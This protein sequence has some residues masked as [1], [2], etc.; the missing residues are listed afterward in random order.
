M[1]FQRRFINNQ[2]V[3]KRMLSIISHQENVNH[4]HSEIPLHTYQDD[5]NNNSNNKNQ[6]ITSTGGDVKKL[7]SLCTVGKNV[8]SCCH[9]E[10]QF[11][12][13]PQKVKHRTMMSPSNA[14]SSF[15]LKRI[16]SSN[17]NRYLYTSAHRNNP[18]ST[19]DGIN[20]MWYIKTMECY[21]AIK[22]MAF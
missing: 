8:K 11:E 14:T 7:E 16:E 21:S 2:Q 4:N 19:D 13:F 9:C 17:L 1:S 22:G 15:I 10:K 20:K 18:R 5:K 6:K 3:Q 12:L